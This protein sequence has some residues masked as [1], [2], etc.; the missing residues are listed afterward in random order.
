MRSCVMCIYCIVLLNIKLYRTPPMGYIIVEQEKQK[1]R[2]HFYSFFMPSNQLN[3]IA[4]KAYMYIGLV[5]Y[6][7]NRESNLGMKEPY[8]PCMQL[9]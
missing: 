6:L 9:I 3:C 2:Q 4:I 1:K 5:I 7:N 8:S